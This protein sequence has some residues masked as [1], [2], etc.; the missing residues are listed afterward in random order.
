MP[1]L[2][3][4]MSGMVS[5]FPAPHSLNRIGYLVVCTSIIIRQRAACLPKI[6]V[7]ISVESNVFFLAMYRSKCRILCPK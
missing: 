2:V 4:R 3:R 5:S 6:G 7:I 1:A